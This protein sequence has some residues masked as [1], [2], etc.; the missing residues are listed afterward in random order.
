MPQRTI[1]W[2]GDNSPYETHFDRDDSGRLV[3]AEDTSGGTVLLEYDESADGGAG[4]WIS[5]GPV[6]LSGNDVTGVGSLTTDSVETVDELTD[7]SGTQHTGQLAD[8]GD[9]QPPANH[10]NTAHS[11]TFVSD[12]DGTERQIWVIANGASDPAGADPEDIIFEESA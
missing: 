5:R 11:L 6:D 8:D 9:P 1:D 12:G 2:G 10:D 4:G 3:V 7:P